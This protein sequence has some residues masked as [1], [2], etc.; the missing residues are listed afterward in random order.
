MTLGVSERLKA[1]GCESDTGLSDEGL[2]MDEA[3]LPRLCSRAWLEPACCREGA[4]LSRLSRT[5]AVLR[6]ARVNNCG[7]RGRRGT[8]H[9]RANMKCTE[10]K[11]E[12]P[13]EDRDLTGALGQVTNF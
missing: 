1:N 4:M 11:T 8:Q 6:H 12:R 3:E 13:R 5:S 2:V 10:K 7:S 9:H